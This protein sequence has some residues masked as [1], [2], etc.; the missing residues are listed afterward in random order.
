MSVETIIAHYGLLAVGIGAAV[1]GEAVVLTGGLLAHQGLMPIAGVM[2]L[3]AI[4]SF[5]ADQTFFLLGRRFRDHTRVRSIAERPV[6]E[7]VLAMLDRHPVGF[8]FTFRFLY[9]F[10]TISPI[11]IGTSTI[12]AWRFLLLN[13]LAAVI[14]AIVIAGAGYAFGQGIE[15]AF[16]RLRRFEHVGLAVLGLI[17]AGAVIGLGVRRLSLAVS[18]KAG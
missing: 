16:G 12:P 10:R 4:G 8:I 18:N 15:L 11:A 9:G 17:A 14:W 3:A 13:G 7:R 6:F 2:A 5:V 1:E